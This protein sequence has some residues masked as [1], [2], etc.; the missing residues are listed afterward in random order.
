MLSKVVQSK[1]T[2]STKQSFNG[3]IV[4][5]RQLMMSIDTVIPRMNVEG[6]W[7]TFKHNSYDINKRK[8]REGGNMLVKTHKN[9]QNGK[10]M[11][12]NCR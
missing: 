11:S 3:S 5:I 4:I 10:D 6:T 12:K 9:M 8:T 2:G 7:Q 1:L